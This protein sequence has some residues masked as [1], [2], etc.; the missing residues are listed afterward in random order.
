MATPMNMEKFEKC[1]VSLK[2]AK[3]TKLFYACILIIEWN[4]A[5]KLVLIKAFI[6]QL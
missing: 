4:S 6:G 1:G 3:W 2:A 5:L